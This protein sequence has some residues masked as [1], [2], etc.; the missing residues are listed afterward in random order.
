[1]INKKIDI[2]SL[3][4]QLETLIDTAG[5][6]CGPVLIKELQRRIDK[7]VEIFNKDVDISSQNSFKV[8]NDRISFCKKIINEKKIIDDSQINTDEKENNPPD[9]IKVHEDRRKNK[10]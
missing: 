7:T 8:Y 1:M 3:A 10:T 4:K 6:S 9:F 2:K 5:D